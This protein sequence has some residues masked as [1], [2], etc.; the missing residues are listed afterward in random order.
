MAHIL[1][2]DDEARIGSLL[3]DELSD[4][5]HRATAVT[6]AAA[7]LAAVEKDAPDIVITDLR[8]AEMDGVTLLKELRHRFPAVDVVVMT[9]YASIETAIATMR[10]GA[11]DYIIK[12]FR[13][14]E[15]AMVVARL[16]E[17]RRLEGENRGLRAAL[18]GGAAGDIIGASAG[19]AEVRR[20]V[21][22]LSRSD[23]AVL[24]RGESGTGKEVVARALH[25]SSAR[26]AGPFIAVNCAAIP[27]TLLESELFGYEKGAF[28]GA[29][30]SKAGHFRLADRGTL[31]L[32]EIGD[33]PAALQSKL[34]RVLETRSFT[35]LGGVKETHVDVRL[36]SATH[37]ALE[38]DIASGRFRQDL[39]YRLNVFPIVIPPLRDRR[40]DIAELARHFLAE[41]G[42]PP[43]HLGDDALARL[44]AH[45]WPGNVRELRNVLER[46]VILRPEGRI[47]AG[48]IMIAPTGAGAATG[49]T[50][51]PP[52]TLNLE[53]AERRLIARALAAAAGNK[54]EAARLLGITRRALYGRLERYGME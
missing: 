7:A 54:S 16:E 35:P 19:M 41:W 39:F 49:T 53:E 21:Q 24:I 3:A 33:L 17:K 44:A 40:E 18:A 11:Y 38:A 52:D 37:Q 12:P 43:A 2:V 4:A 32:D 29:V 48:D 30:R 10:E 9:A 5:G 25:R 22:S 6:S 34:L 45:D 8:M 13:G 1:I 27:E 23:A 47:G 50:A 36:V 28:T 46:A 51:P 14:E 20:L 15:V 26:S 31:F 42:R